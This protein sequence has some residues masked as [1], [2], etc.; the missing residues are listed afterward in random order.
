MLAYQATIPVGSTATVRLPK[1]GG[2]QGKVDVVTAGGTTVYGAGAFKAAVPGITG[3]SED[4]QAV[5]LDVGSG[6]YSFVVH[7]RT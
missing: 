3:G 7:V 2:A 5:V 6:A 1:M 4:G